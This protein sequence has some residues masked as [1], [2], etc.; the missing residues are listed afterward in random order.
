MLPDNV[1]LFTAAGRAFQH[2]DHDCPNGNPLQYSCLENSMD[3]GAWWATAHGVTKSWTRL[4]DFTMTSLQLDLQES[5]NVS[6][7]AVAPVISGE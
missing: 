3:G 4:S 6:L 5:V 7:D 2:A 1:P